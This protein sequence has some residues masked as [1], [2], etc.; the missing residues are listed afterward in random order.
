MQHTHTAHKDPC[1]VTPVRW[2]KGNKIMNIE[3]SSTIQTFEQ[4]NEDT[5]HL[6]N[7]TRIKKIMSCFLVGF[8]F[9]NV[10]WMFRLSRLY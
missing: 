6:K 2:K 10:F 5:W 1:E 7:K 9:K 3:I 8:S 4:E